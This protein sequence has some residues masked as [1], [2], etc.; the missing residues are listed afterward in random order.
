M[1]NNKNGAVAPGAASNS[2]EQIKAAR[3]LSERERKDTS[4]LLRQ[5]RK[6]PYDFVKVA[7]TINLPYE[8]FVEQI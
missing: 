3:E 5:A 7:F 1:L 2:K 4:R 6:S 8:M